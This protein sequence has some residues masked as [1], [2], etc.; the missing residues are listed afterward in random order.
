MKEFAKNA[1]SKINLISTNKS[2]EGMG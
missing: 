1:E 2:W